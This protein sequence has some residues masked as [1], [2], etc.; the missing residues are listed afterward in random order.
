MANIPPL[1]AVSLGYSLTLKHFIS[2][3][4]MLH[5]FIGGTVGGR[6]KYLKYSDFI[7]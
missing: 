5:L 1:P 3:L 4:L 6:E 7:I 2:V